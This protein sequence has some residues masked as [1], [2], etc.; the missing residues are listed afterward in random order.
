MKHSPSPQRPNI[1]L[2]TTD[3]QRADHIGLKGLR[4]IQTP[5][6]DRLGREGIHFDRAY[7]PSPICTPCRVSLLTGQYPSRHGAYSI[8]V[9]LPRFPRPTLPD[10]LGSNG[11]R[12]ALIGKSHF[13]SRQDE[14][15]HMAGQRDPSPE[16]FREWN[17]P[18]LGFD[19]IAGSSGHSMNA[20][21]VQHYR[22]FLE[23]AGVDW[24]DWFPSQQNNYDHHYCGPWN[25]PEEYHDTSWVADQT[26]QFMNRQRASEQPWFCWA[27]FQDP[28]EPFACPEPWYSSVDVAQ[29]EI[30]ED[31][32]AGEFA[33]RHPVYA[34]CY[35]RELGP[36]RDG[37]G[38]PCVYGSEEKTS[39]RLAAMQATLGMVAFIDNRVGHLMRCLEQNGQLEN[40]VIIYTSDHG[41]LHGHHGLWGKGITAY[42]D[43]QRVP[44]LIWGPRWVQ[45]LG[46]VNALANLVDL[47]RTV[48][49]LC[50]TEIPAVMQGTDL[51]PIL[52]G[53]VDRVQD[54]TIVECRPTETTLRQRTLIT[55][56]FKLVVYH[57]RED[58]ELYDLNTD[59]D[60]YMNLWTVPEM[61]H[62]KTSMLLK[63]AQSGMEG[64]FPVQGRVAF[65]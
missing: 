26:E 63:L 34:A 7:C 50:G 22:N 60:Q 12:T 33:D 21:P 53:E 19:E 57:D 40:T 31:Y 48:L 59:P 28:H 49:Q 51:G 62:I 47:P 58:G 35:K 64:E 8:G 36:W 5:H 3:Q 15:T 37:P 17:G 44:L 54:F 27:S 32:R 25:I 65:S 2:I 39:R 16:F 55:D 61:A 30:P 38:V 24:S 29:M 9:T 23:D 41:E 46:T 13:V 20:L 11:Y 4:A 42:E 52:R 1:L 56:R 43:C 14:E 18:Y 10:I 45:T 6:L